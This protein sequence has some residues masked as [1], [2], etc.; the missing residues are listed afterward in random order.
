MRIIMTMNEFDR[1]EANL[2]ASE[3]YWQVE[4]TRDEHRL[5]TAKALFDAQA[6][7]HT[8]VPDGYL[9]CLIRAGVVRMGRRF[10]VSN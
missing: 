4:V 8:I 10:P 9:H 1:I 5:E 6:K 3:K 2:K 7:A